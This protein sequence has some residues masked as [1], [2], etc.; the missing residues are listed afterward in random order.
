MYLRVADL[1]INHCGCPDSYL[2]KEVTG[3]VHQPLWFIT[4]ATV[5]L[6]DDGGSLLTA[7][8]RSY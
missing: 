5:W 1:L 2:F 8:R 4:M 6:W 3:A 7:L